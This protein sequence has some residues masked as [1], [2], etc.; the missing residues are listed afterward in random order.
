MP[1]SRD[2]CHVF[3]QRQVSVLARLPVAVPV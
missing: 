1:R 2:G 3:H